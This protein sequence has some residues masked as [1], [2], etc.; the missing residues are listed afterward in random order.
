MVFFKKKLFKNYILFEMILF[1][2]SEN[3]TNEFETK[4]KIKYKDKIV[5]GCNFFNLN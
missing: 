5:V 2:K 3:I 4:I 1:Y